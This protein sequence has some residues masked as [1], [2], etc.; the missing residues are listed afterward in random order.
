MYNISNLRYLKTSLFNVYG[1]DTKAA[2]SLY[3]LAR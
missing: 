3:N 2:S 1:F